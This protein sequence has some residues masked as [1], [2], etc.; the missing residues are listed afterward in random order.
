[1]S[2]LSLQDSGRD[3][4]EISDDTEQ[5]FFRISS[6]LDWI[7][8]QTENKRILL[9]S[10]GNQKFQKTLLIKWKYKPHDARKCVATVFLRKG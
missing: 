1:M 10:S 5:N 2:T 6:E 3:V 4:V 8:S 7:S 9:E